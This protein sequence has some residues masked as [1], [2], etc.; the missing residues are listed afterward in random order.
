[1]NKKALVLIWTFIM[2]MFVAVP[3]TAADNKTTVIANGECGENA[4]WT[5]DSNGVLTISGTGDMNNSSEYRQYRSDIKSVI[6]EDGITSMPMYAFYECI[7]LTSVK[8]SKNL[9]EISYGAFKSCKNLSG[10]FVIPDNVEKITR[11][12][13]SD[14]SKVES[15]ILGKKVNY[16]DINTFDG[17][18]GVRNVTFRGNDVP[19]DLAS[20]KIFEPMNQL[21]TIYVPTEAYAA[22]AKRYIQKLHGSK[23]LVDSED[24]MVIYDN[25]LVLYN[26]SDADVKIPDSVKSIG[27]FAFYNKRKEIESVELGKNTKVIQPNSFLECSTLKSILFND[28]L[29]EIGDAAFKNCDA[30]TQITLSN[31]T[32]VGEN[33]F[34]DCDKLETVSLGKL[35]RINT[36]MFFD[37][38][39]LSQVDIGKVTFIGE[40]AFEGCQNLPGMFPLNNVTKIGYKAFKDCHGM[41]GTLII[42]DSVTEIEE[43]AFE[44][45][46]NIDSITIGSGLKDIGGYSHSIPFIGMSGVK[47]I[48]FKGDA[49]PPFHVF[50]IFDTM[51]ELQ[52]IYVPANGVK[53][54]V[55][56]LN[57]HIGA[58]QIR[59]W[60]SDEALFIQDGIL[61]LYQ[62]D[63]EE[64][65]LP[66]EIKKILPGAFRNN[67]SLKKVVL[68]DNV[69]EIGTKS[70]FQCDTLEEV[71]LNEKLKTIKYSAFEKC[72]AL[73]KVTFGDALTQIGDSAFSGCINLGGTL[74]IP[75]T[76][77]EIGESAFKDCTSLEGVILNNKLT[78]IARYTFSGCTNLKGILQIPEKVTDIEEYAF[79]NCSSLE[80]LSLGTNVYSVQ[81]AA[82]RNCTGITELKLNTK[83]KEIGRSAFYNCSNIPGSLI[84]PDNVTKIGSYAF[85][86]CDSLTEIIVEG[87]T[88]GTSIDYQAFSECDL[89]ANVTLKN[90]ITNIEKAAFKDC[91]SLES[92][93][94][95]D[96]SQ[97][98]EKL[99]SGCKNLSHVGMD[100][101]TTIEK[102]AFKGCTSLITMFNLDRVTRIGEGAFQDCTGLSGNLILPDNVTD[103]GSY[104]FYNCSGL[105]SVQLPESITTIQVGLF[106]EC[107]GLTEL[108]IPDNVKTIGAYA[109]TNCSN[110]EK[111]VFGKSVSYGG[112]DGYPPALP[113]YGMSGVKTIVFK[114]SELP[115]FVGIGSQKDIFRSMNNL[116]VIYVP[117]NC[118]EKYEAAYGIYIH[119][120]S[121]QE[122]DCET[123]G[124]AHNWTDYIIEKE[125][126]CTESGT[127]TKTCKECGTI[128]T[129][130]LPALGHTM[131][132]WY[133]VK[134]A[135]YDEDGKEERICNT[136]D[137]YTETQIIPKFELED[138]VL[139]ITNATLYKGEKIQLTINCLPITPPSEEINWYSNSKTV[140]T[141][142]SNGEVTAISEGTAI[143]TATFR[144]ISVECKIDVVSGKWIKD[145]TGWW[146]QNADHSYPYNCW[147]KIN[148]NWYYFNNSGYLVTGW[149]WNSGHWYYLDSTTGIMLENEWMNN[150]YFQSNGAMATGWVFL[151]SNYY[152]FY[153]NGKMASNCWIGNY[154]LKNDGKMAVNEWVD[155]NKYYV[156]KTGKYL[157]YTGWLSL[158]NRWYYLGNGGL[159]QTGWIYTGAWYYANPDENGA[160]IENSWKTIGNSE[161]YFH[162]GGAMATGWVL[163]DDEYYYFQKNGSKATNMWI[164]NY[165]VKSNG[166]MAKNEWVDNDKYYVDE[167][168]RWNP[169]TTK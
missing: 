121:I 169:N 113:F 128:E 98:P 166:I 125:A 93:E 42:P 86:N 154:Y 124:L 149:L 102:E 151:D 12:S 139:N 122:L 29:E 21:E 45:C 39:M 90:N 101:V 24:D 88:R 126:S 74:V 168:G 26:G 162:K 65:I 91:V 106:Q 6:M 55:S 163:L 40:S 164:G 99:F 52:T 107:R 111:L 130:L 54:Y 159:K 34:Y 61:C 37:C 68:N 142:T 129:E 141:V 140:A 71:I 82:F 80:G 136:C 144:G 123:A 119:N 95:G 152:Y 2:C 83:L 51:T 17:M 103:I 32:T 97:I 135:S 60:D 18:T 114:N 87:S 138:M 167:S 147:K 115:K 41:T 33:V 104:A 25:I 14:C 23:L 75:D 35:T 8:L 160:L 165:Y 108:I 66:P 79:E 137:E 31:V 46:Y 69:T 148:G 156:D 76:V 28:A 7:N 63:E 16:I 81:D 134:E 112:N 50:Y 157:S 11:F 117:K 1:M 13:F 22:Y 58:A 53:D 5:L 153:S 96:I 85:N 73:N 36:G 70:F 78:Q 94:L 133:I 3:V 100:K 131:S 84:L 27:S 150:Y 43:Y 20:G 48:T 72:T 49:V 56:K 89:L 109:F 4:R 47:T 62:G 143:I 116:E 110:I 146:Y 158:N 19:S 120:A 67:H 38:D 155:Y 15:L 92:A 30:I 59:T 44:N 64:L 132:E 145:S 127:K 10:E 105:T 9:T 77:T 57:Y 161:Y 118:T